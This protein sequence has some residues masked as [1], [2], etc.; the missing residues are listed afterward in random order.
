MSGKNSKVS[1]NLINFLSP[2]TT[3]LKADDGKKIYRKSSGQ[4]ST[5]II[6]SFE[7]L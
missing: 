3:Q 2:V 7:K 1:I 4:K 5:T 6:D